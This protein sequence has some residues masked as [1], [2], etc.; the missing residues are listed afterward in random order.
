MR[1]VGRWESSINV[2]E[3]TAVLVSNYSDLEGD[4]PEYSRLDRRGSLW[5][6]VYVLLSVAVEMK[7][8]NV[9]VFMD[10]CYKGSVNLKDTNRENG[11]WNTSFSFNN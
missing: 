8:Q 1:E 9:R 11:W 10:A 4:V 2:R 3:E 7:Q 5:A 6:L